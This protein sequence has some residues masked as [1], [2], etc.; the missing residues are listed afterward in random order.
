MPEHPAEE[1]TA[2]TLAGAEGKNL[3]FPV[4]KDMNFAEAFTL[5]QMRS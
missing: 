2:A 1:K 3:M 5:K 4:A